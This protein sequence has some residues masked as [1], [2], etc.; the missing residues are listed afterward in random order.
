MISTRSLRAPW[1]CRGLLT[2]L[3]IAAAATCCASARGQGS[4]GITNLDTGLANAS[5]TPLSELPGSPPPD[6]TNRTYGNIITTEGGAPQTVT[7]SSGYSLSLLFSSLDPGASFTFA[8]VY[9]PDGRSLLLTQ[10]QATSKTAFPDG[11]AV[12]WD[13]SQGL[14]FL[15]PSTGAGT[16]DAGEATIA[17]VDQPLLIYLHTGSILTVS[18]TASTQEVAV[19]RPVS[20]DATVAGASSNATL[21]YRWSF[22]DG[23]GSSTETPVSHSYVAPGTYDVYLRVTGTDDSLGFSSLIPITVGK[24]PLGPNRNGG[25]TNE[26]EN[27]ATSGAGVKGSDTKKSTGTGKSGGAKATTSATVAVTDTTSASTTTPVRS[28]ARDRGL[29]RSP[30]SGGLLSG[31]AVSGESEAP[32]RAAPRAAAPAGAAAP[33]RTGHLVLARRAPGEGFWISLGVLATLISGALLELTGL[34]RISPR[35]RSAWLIIR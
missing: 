19:N 3:T 29:K 28:S 2:V 22:G 13:D 33:A 1:W 35:L 17:A 20:F 6:V 14:H 15:M 31:I 27:A 16:A 4:V 7:V 12:V 25:G 8:E 24:A 34:P 5:A 26:K 23:A 10:A 21:R 9:L 32:A 11:P 30:P 18:V